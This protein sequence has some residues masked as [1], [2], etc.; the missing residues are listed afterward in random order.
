MGVF[1]DSGGTVSVKP[2]DKLYRRF[3]N[4]RQ[5]ISTSGKELIESFSDFPINTMNLKY[6]SF[7]YT[8]ITLI[9]TNTVTHTIGQDISLSYNT[10]TTHPVYENDHYY[11][12]SLSVDLG[13][14]NRHSYIHNSD[15]PNAKTIRGFLDV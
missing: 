2:E 8:T 12:K 14:S 1:S 15:T 5:D 3:I 9:T 13:G 7:S 11:M 4:I 10:I 6:V